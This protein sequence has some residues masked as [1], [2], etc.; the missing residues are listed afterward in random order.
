MRKLSVK[1]TD[2]TNEI[3]IKKNVIKLDYFDQE[4]FEEVLFFNPKIADVYKEGQKDYPQFKELHQDVFDSLYKYAPFKYPEE[5]IDYDYLLNSQIM[6][7]IMRSIKYRELRN[8][9]RLD[10]I[11][12][13][14]GTQILG[15]EVKELID[16]L[17]EEFEK[18]MAEA[19]QALQDAK[20]AA[21]KALQ[22]QLD[23]IDPNS[24]P[25]SRQ[26]AQAKAQKDREYSLKEAKKRLEEH[27]KKFKKTTQRKVRRNTAKMLDTAISQTTETS[28]MITNWGLEQDPTYSTTG[29]Q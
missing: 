12:S 6:D 22:E 24:D 29:Y 13:T 16:Q 14:I 25:K 21:D 3:R 17:R 10:P 27:M 26:A 2:I 19:A 9:T 4:A 28:N 20:D 11:Q 15:E 23:D 18:K 5:D 7:E 8:L 1:I